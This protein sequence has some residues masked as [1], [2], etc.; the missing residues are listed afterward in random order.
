MSHSE[1]TSMNIYNSSHY[2]PLTPQPLPF[3]TYPSQTLPNGKNINQIMSSTT[4]ALMNTPQ[5]TAT[6]SSNSMNK[7]SSSTLVNLLHQKRSPLIDQS[8]TQEKPKTSVKQTRK[9][10]QKKTQTKRLTTANND[11]Q[12]NLIKTSAF[13]FL[14]KNFVF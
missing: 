3:D 1:L 11:I 2:E 10:P 7:P 5:T 14:N 6:Y 12:V 9:S 13:F 4:N 8:I